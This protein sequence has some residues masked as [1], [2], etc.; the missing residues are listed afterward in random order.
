MIDSALTQFELRFQSLF[1][2]GRGYSF[3]CDPEG[4]VDLNQLSD[5]ARD[6]YLYARAVVGRELAFPAVRPGGLH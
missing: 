6:N 3:P 1:D 5:R 4:H 2:S